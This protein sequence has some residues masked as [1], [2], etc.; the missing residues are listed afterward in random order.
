M[1][2]RT[3]KIRNRFLLGTY[4]GMLCLITLAMENEKIAI[5]LLLMMNPEF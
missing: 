2:A 5:T 1:Q 4:F 3:L